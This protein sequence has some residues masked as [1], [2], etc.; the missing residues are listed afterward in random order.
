MGQV[1]VFKNRPS[2][3]CGREPLKIFIW[4]ILEYLDQ[5][6]LKVL[7]GHIFWQ[8][9]CLVIYRTFIDNDKNT[10]KIQS[11]QCF[12]LRCIRFL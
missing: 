3:T 11:K 7:T 1:K 6:S 4:F 5:Y 10:K 8:Q 2:K 12:P 9:S